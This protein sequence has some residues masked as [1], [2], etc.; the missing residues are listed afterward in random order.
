MLYMQLK[1]SRLSLLF[2]EHWSRSQVG[3]EFCTLRKAVIITA[4]YSA[5]AEDGGGA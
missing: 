1:M 4:L 5:E 3:L 2:E